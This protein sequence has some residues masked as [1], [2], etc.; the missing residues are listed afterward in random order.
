MEWDLYGEHTYSKAPPIA[1][2]KESIDLLKNEIPKLPLFSASAKYVNPGEYLKVDYSIVSRA[3]FKMQEILHRYMNPNEK[4]KALLLCEGPGG[5]QQA[6]SKFFKRLEWQA[7]TL[8]NAIRWEG[9]DVSRVIFQDIIKDPLPRDLK[10]SLC[11]GDGGFE[12]DPS[13][14]EEENYAL[15]EAQMLKGCDCLLPEGNLIVKLFD[16]FQPNTQG[17][18]MEIARRFDR[19][20]ILKPFGSRICNSERYFI[21]LNKRLIPK[22]ESVTMERIHQIINDFAIIQIAGLQEAVKLARVPSIPKSLLEKPCRRHIEV[23]EKFSNAM[24]SIY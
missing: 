8:P 10:V 5:F 3:Y 16:M 18:I 6:C 15:F 12:A 20:I 14:Q 2:A 24:N 4:T 1:N 22:A 23:A 13:K 19:A 9:E 17:L 11:T 21:G 7:L